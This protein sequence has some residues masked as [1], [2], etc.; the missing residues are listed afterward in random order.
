MNRAHTEEPRAAPAT[1]VAPIA[2]RAAAAPQAAAPA[3]PATLDPS[4]LGMLKKP[5]ADRP[6]PLAALRA[7]QSPR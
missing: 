6:D 2:P 5:P 3:S 7:I 4:R 1:P